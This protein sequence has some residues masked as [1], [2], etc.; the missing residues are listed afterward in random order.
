[1]FE[2][3][4]KGQLSDENQSYPDYSLCVAYWIFFYQIEL[5]NLN[6]PF[7][8]SELIGIGE[9]LIPLLTIVAIVLQIKSIKQ[10]ETKKGNAVILLILILV[11]ICSFG[12]TYYTAHGL[13]TGGLFA[14]AD[15]GEED[16]TYYFYVDQEYRGKDYSL[17]LE[18]DELTYDRLIEDED[19][20]YHIEF[21]W[22]T[23]T[24]HTGFLVSIDLDDFCDNDKRHLFELRLMFI[25]GEYLWRHQHFRYNQVAYLGCT[26]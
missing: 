15:K 12:D 9:Y 10:K 6:V 23:L 2:K 3:G 24:P 5:R 26:P 11:L 14:V 13:N 17:Q 7:A 20:Q 8:I 21:I 25:T 4:E 16:G 19:V 1:M 22:N 18:C